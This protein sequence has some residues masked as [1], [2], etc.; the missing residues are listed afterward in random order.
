MAKNEEIASLSVSLSLDSGNFS[1]SISAI[2][3][4][5]RALDKDFKNSAKGIEGFEGSFEGVSKKLDTVGK[6]MDLYNK[7]LEA[8]KKEYDSNV[9]LIEK[10]VEKLNDLE[11][12]LGK[13]SDKWKKQAELVAKNSA[14][15]RKLGN[16]ISATE[17]DIR[18]LTNE[19]NDLEK[20]LKSFDT[21]SLVKDF[22]KLVDE[23]K[24]TENELTKLSE[25]LDGLNDKFSGI[26]LGFGAIGAGAIAGAIEADN[27][28]FSIQASLGLTGKE[29]ENVKDRVQDLAENGFDFG[30]SVEAIKQVQQVLGGL[31]NE[32]EVDELANELLVFEKAFGAD[33]Q[34]SIKATNSIMRNFG[35]TSQEATDVIA[36]GFQ[37]GLNYSDE[38]LD[39]L[40]EYSVQFASMG[41]SAEQTLAIL[42]NGFEGGA[43]S[44]DKVADGVKEF[45]IRLREI[46]KAQE[47]ALSG[48]GLN[49]TEVTNALN[50]GGASASQMAFKVANALMKVSDETKRNE[51]SI[52]LFGTMAE[53]VGLNVV[54]AMKGISN[55]TLNITGS[56]NKVAEAYEE[57]FGAKLQSV[58]AQL[59][60]PLA[61]VGKVL[62][63]ILLPIAQVAG[64]FAKVIS[65]V[66]GLD[67][68]VACIVG[69]GVA[70]SPLLKLASGL[71]LAFG[72]GAGLTGAFAAI[73]TFITGTLIPVFSSI[74]TVITGTVIPAIS[75]LVATFGLPVLAIGAVIG[76][77]AALIKNWDS[78]KEVCKDLGEV[79]SVVFKNIKKWTVDTFK[80]MY[81]SISKKINEIKEVCTRVFS[82][83]YDSITYP[84]KKAK[85]FID[86][87]MNG[88]SSTIDKI[89]PFN[90]SNLETIEVQGTY[91]LSEVP[92]VRSFDNLA[93]TMKS[94]DYSS[95]R[96]NIPNKNNTTSKP[97]SKNIK[98][99][100]EKVL[101]SI[102]LNIENFVNNDKK[103][104][105][106]LAN[107][108]MYFMNRK[109]KALGG[110]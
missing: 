22:N 28:L 92:Q 6:K 46:G 78:I 91:S 103:D 10:Q 29:A 35:I 63:D 69:L 95:S 60:E 3:K 59:K 33:L 50:E 7:K 36:W 96:Y 51:Y 21:K 42:K 13:G 101:T 89:N 20:E 23:I 18:K 79:I 71:A 45:G 58:V 75:S 44:I 85:E 67:I 86:N 25:N 49:I 74:G 106:Q 24:N 2:N 81:D 14:N 53:D 80:N 84:F 100:E 54:K 88:I 109:S 102:N 83:I 32:K 37:N 93:N 39:T 105:E 97:S 5:I 87:I 19:F 73:G 11:K 52:A 8:Q 62:L 68:L 48:L 16:D 38:F 9:E 41:L 34:E 30:D 107:E 99:K 26:S 15:L 66:P 40:N 57:T 90:K 98:T 76:V 55:E 31:L 17:G 61:E 43:Y 1:K 64:A 65:I 70:I 82:K 27:A 77:G 110:I 72:N 56:A 4:E 47:G 104:I 108:L 94:L 12:E